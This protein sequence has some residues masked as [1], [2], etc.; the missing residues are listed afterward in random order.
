MKNTP[1]SADYTKIIRPFISCVLFL[2]P[3]LMKYLI[4]SSIMYID[5]LNGKCTKF[6]RLHQTHHTLHLLRF[7]SVSKSKE[8]LS[9]KQLNQ[10]YRL[11]YYFVT[12]SFIFIIAAIAQLQQHLWNY[13]TSNFACNPFKRIFI[14]KSH[15]KTN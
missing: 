5:N 2:F 12:I 3:N 4:L 11:Q 13:F 1:I 9:S 8:M 6:I 7:I 14:L 15:F 10:M